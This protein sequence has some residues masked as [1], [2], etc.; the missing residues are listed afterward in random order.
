MEQSEL[1]EI[2]QQV[3]DL[4][5][6]RTYSQEIQLWLFGDFVISEQFTRGR[7]PF[8][9]LR[10]IEEDMKKRNKRKLNKK[11]CVLE[12]NGYKKVLF[13]YEP[14][15]GVNGLCLNHPLHS[16]NTETFKPIYYIHKS[17]CMAEIFQESMQ[18]LPVCQFEDPQ[19]ITLSMATF[20]VTKDGYI[21]LVRRMN[22]ANRL[23]GWGAPGRGTMIS[24]YEMGLEVTNETNVYDNLFE[25]VGFS[26]QESIKKKSEQPIFKP[27]FIQEGFIDSDGRTN[28]DSSSIFEKD[29]CMSISSIRTHTMVLFF[30]CQV[31]LLKKEIDINPKENQTTCTCWLTY[32]QLNRVLS[33]KDTP[34]I[35]SNET[36]GEFSIIDEEEKEEVYKADYLVRLN[37]LESSQRRY[38]VQSGYVEPR[39]LSGKYPNNSCGEGMAEEDYYA[40]RF[41]RDNF[42]Y[43]FC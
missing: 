6:G 42:K 4:V 5:K 43:L 32:G 34:E 39:Q 7:C 40:F 35:D 3:K 10:K 37:K 13:K 2:K 29:D 9:F 20:L 26:C 22:N 24:T 15:R 38:K 21:L 27:V 14:K 16:L 41:L 31:P 17:P 30:Y 12:F 23:P 25:D 11:H 8:G 19:K 1:S 33:Y 36:Q 28:T 18:K